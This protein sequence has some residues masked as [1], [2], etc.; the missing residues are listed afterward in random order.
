MPRINTPAELNHVREHILSTRDPERPCVTICTGTGCLALGAAEVAAAFKAIIQQQG[1]PVE[2]DLR[3]TGCHGFCERGTVV[4][5]HPEEICYLQVQ[6]G[7]AEEVVNRTVVGKEIVERLL[8][9]DAAGE[10]VEREPEIGFYKQQ[11]RLLIGQ[12]LKIDPRSID[13]Y[14]AGAATPPWPGRCSS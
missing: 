2:V 11:Q 4:I 9:L 8:Y 5:I 7:D 6:P 14:L 1:L 12:N 10:R 13:D 3:E